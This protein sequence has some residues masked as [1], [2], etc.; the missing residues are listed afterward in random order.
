MRAQVLAWG[1]AVASG[2]DWGT[3][4]HVVDVGGGAGSLLVTLLTRYP[5]LRGTIVDLPAA[6]DTAQATLA[7]AGLAARSDVVSGSFFDPLPPGADAYVLSQILHDW[8]D[9]AACRILQRCAEAAGPDGTVFIVE[10]TGELGESM[11][12]GMDLR[13]LVYFGGKERS[14]R[15]FVALGERAGLRLVA[16]HRAF[17]LSIIELRAEHA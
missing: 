14:A 10:R 7:A 16:V 13:M 3:L 6:T 5:A 15:Q 8:N 1:A 9:D 2:Y 4:G 12:T 17:P 11:H